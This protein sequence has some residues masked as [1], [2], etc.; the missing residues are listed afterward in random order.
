MSNIQK[1]IAKFTFKDGQLKEFH[2]LLNDPV[3]GLNFTKKCNGFIDI[4]CLQD[5]DNS[6]TLIYRQERNR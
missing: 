1:V 5:Q 3:N 6:N 4:E 2:N